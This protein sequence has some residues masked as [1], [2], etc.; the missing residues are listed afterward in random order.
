VE[1]AEAA[2]HY[3]A[4]GEGDHVVGAAAALTEASS[5]EPDFT[6]DGAVELSPARPAAL[7][8]PLSSAFD[9]AES[10]SPGHAVR[11]AHIALTVAAELGLDVATRRTVLYG[12][13]LHDAGVA[14]A[15]LPPGAGESGGHTAAG[16]WVAELFGL[17]QPIQDAIRYSHER[18]DGQ[19]RPHG[20]AG[21][22]VP[23]EALLVSAAHWATDIAESPKSPLRARVALQSAHPRELAEMA[24]PEIAEALA[25]VVRD[26][27]TWTAL[28]DD[29]LAARVTL[30]ANG[31]G[32]ASLKNVERIAAATGQ[33]VDMAL[34]EPGR[35]GR[36]AE[37]AVQ[38]ARRVGVPA[39]E[40]Q[41]LGVAAQ[42][43]DIGQLDVPRH[44]TE[45]PAI[46]SLEEM[47]LMRHHP[48]M[49]ARIIE[50]VPGMEELALW[51]HAHH[52]RPDGRGY[53]EML[54]E[55]ELPLASR[56]MA[57]ADTYWALR[58]DRP[59]REAFDD[60]EAVEILEA[61]AGQIYDGDVVMLLKPS[62]PD[63]EAP[64]AETEA[65][66]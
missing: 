5:D 57:V 63:V 58:A 18:W 44:V 16:A 12:A 54:E 3:V 22:E 40:R 21:D 39:A 20:L 32:E 24:G 36:V 51:V 46:L 7:I 65:A 15:T 41:A 43:M 53:P 56:V 30:A 9:L 42:L 10:Q 60:R 61:G 23:V 26:D 13:L 11:V 17:D 35:S 4:P 55:D 59:H 49:G 31:D 38:L 62:L 48:G 52:E 19:G 50:Q 47:E 1:R 28:W 66:G 6:L 8:A 14:A 27:A 29:H 33:V 45:K 25:G 64:D 2:D 37:L 34:R